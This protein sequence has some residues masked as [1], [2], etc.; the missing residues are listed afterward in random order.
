MIADQILLD[1]LDAIAY[2]VRQRKRDGLSWAAWA[3]E[4]RIAAVKRMEDR[5]ANQACQP[6]H[7]PSSDSK[8]AGS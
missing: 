8:S 2:A 3:F 6:I 7:W 1:D 4:A 5:E